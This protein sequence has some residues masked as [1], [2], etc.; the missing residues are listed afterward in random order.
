[1]DYKEL[2]KNR[3]DRMKQISAHSYTMEWENPEFMDF[4]LGGL[5]QIRRFRKY[6][7]ISSE[8]EKLEKL[9]ST[10]DSF[11]TNKVSF[12]KKIFEDS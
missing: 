3:K 12:L 10:Y 11:L 5:P 9:I 2:N 6:K 8:L 7:N 1:M 4:L